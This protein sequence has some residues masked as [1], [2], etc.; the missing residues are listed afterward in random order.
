MSNLIDTPSQIDFTMVS[1]DTKTLRVKIV[2]VDRQPFDLS[3][4]SGATWAFAK[5]SAGPVLFAKTLGDGVNIVQVG[6]DWFTDIEIDP[7]DTEEL[8][9]GDYYH[10]AQLVLADG[11]IATP[12][13]GLITIVRDLIQ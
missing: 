12:Y 7:E 8:K 11:A 5:N 6:D 2:G 1:G 4:V 10:E 13:S 9:A 3:G